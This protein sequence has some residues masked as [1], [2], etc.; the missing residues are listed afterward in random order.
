MAKSI[1][2]VINHITI[3]MSRYNRPYFIAIDGRSAA[4]KSTFA[5]RLSEV[6]N[7]LVIHGDDFFAGGVDIRNEPPSRLAA[8]C[9]NWREQVAAIESLQSTGVAV[10]HRFDWQAFD[11][12][13]ERALTTL[14]VQPI[15][16]LEGVYSARPELR[17]YFD[18]FILIEVDDQRRKKQWLK[19]EGEITAWDKQ[20]LEAEDWYF[21]NISH[22]SLFDF[23]VS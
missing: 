1:N 10:Y 5:S 14:T 16:I 7:S 12:T 18:C 23:I 17:S 11:G 9:I 22:R 20:W 8:S 6:V 21:A 19:R 4:G 2:D 3:Q 15:V 13:Q